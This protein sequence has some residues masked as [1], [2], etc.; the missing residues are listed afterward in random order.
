[1]SWTP[2]ASQL[3]RQRFTIKVSDGKGGVALQTVETTVINP[4]PNRVPVIMSTPRERVRV[5]TPYVYVIEAEDADGDALTYSLV[6][7]PAGMTIEGNVIT[8]VPTLSQS[9]LQDVAVRVTDSQGGSV[10]QGFQVQV[11]HVQE[12]NSPVI[13]SA[14]GTF[15]ANLGREYRYDLDGL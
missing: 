9:G 4:I 5:E 1:V 7:A 10:T 13:T 8:W 12:N 11:S 14:P 2:N 3:G 15:V 6:T